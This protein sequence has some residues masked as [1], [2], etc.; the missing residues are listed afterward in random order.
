MITPTRTNARPAFTLT[1]LLVVVAII[2]VLAGVAV[3]ITLNVLSQ[4]KVDVAHAHM[5]GTLAPAV[6]QYALQQGAVPPSGSMA[7]FLA[8]PN[9]LGS[10]QMDHII[11]PWGREYQVITQGDDPDSF[12]FEIISE[13][14]SPGS[15]DSRIVYASQ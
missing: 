11:D 4:A 5:K 15:P 2:V 8:P 9:G 13:G 6:K 7:T 14:P 3:P 10:L 12:V 1:E